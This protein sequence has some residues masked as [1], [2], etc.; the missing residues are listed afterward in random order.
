M[1]CGWSRT[2]QEAALFLFY[3]RFSFVQGPGKGQVVII[4]LA[5]GKILGAS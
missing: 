1:L 4:S 3:D 5:L 2:V